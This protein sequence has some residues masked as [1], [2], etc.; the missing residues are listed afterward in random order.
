[1]RT[2]G[3]LFRQGRNRQILGWFGGGLVVL[4]AG[5]WV[6]ATLLSRPYSPPPPQLQAVHTTPSAGGKLALGVFV[7]DPELGDGPRDEM[8]MDNFTALVG[9]KPAAWHWYETFG[10]KFP[11]ATFDALSLRGYTPVL[12][13]DPSKADHSDI[14]W[15]RVAAGDVD[16]LIHDFARNATAWG[17]PF[18]LRPEWE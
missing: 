2:L 10:T 13:W 1:M 16:N 12:S 11:K 8:L 9:G 6:V 18:F 3:S 4:A 17:K 14:S 7:N 5:I 15:E